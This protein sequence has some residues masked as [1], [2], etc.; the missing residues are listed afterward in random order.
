[1]IQDAWREFIQ[2]EIFVGEWSRRNINILPTAT[3]ALGTNAT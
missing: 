3:G 1:M 2:I